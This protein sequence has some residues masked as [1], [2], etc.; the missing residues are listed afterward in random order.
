[1]TQLENLNE[2]DDFLDRCHYSM[3][4]QDE[5]N[6]LNCPIIPMQIEGIIKTLKNKQ[7]NKQKK[8]KKTHRALFS[9][10]TILLDIQR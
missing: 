7:T 2:I 3:L 6:N 8:P 1:L 9:L 10:C 4:S 5:I